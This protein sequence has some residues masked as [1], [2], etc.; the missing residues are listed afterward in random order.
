[1]VEM[2]ALHSLTAELHAGFL[3]L[4]FVCIMIVAA[5][6]IVVRLKNRMP[7]KLVNLAIRVRGYTEAAGYVA[8]IGGLLGL[9]LSAWTGMY[10]WPM[11]RLLESG[12]IRNKILLTAFATVMWGGVVFIRT[13][14]GRALWT[15]PAMAAVYTGLTFLAFGVLGMSGSLGAHTT[16]GE[17]VLDPLWN[18]IGVEI[19]ETIALDP[20]VAAGIAL[21]SVVLLLIS[22]LVAR[23]YD[24]FSVKLAPETCQKV[25][26]WDEPKIPETG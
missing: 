1:M 16:K 4:A 2:S 3:T 10:A 9:F 18:I 12:I 15:C 6:Q 7:R 5:A 11:D 20:N 22:L 19:Q 26:K 21:A 13:R 24:L 8:A 25:F 23:R 17:S 14:F